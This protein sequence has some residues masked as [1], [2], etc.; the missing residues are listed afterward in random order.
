MTRNEIINELK[1]YFQIKNLVCKHANQKYSLM[2]WQFLSTEILE[3][4]LVLR[5]DILK[6]PLI[7]NDYPNGCFTQRGLRC[8][9]CEIVKGKSASK[10]MYLSAHVRGNAFDLQSPNMTAAQMRELI[11]VNASK[12]PHPIRIEK[13]V[14]WLHVDCDVPYE[15]AAKIVEF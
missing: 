7:C 12:L 10:T 2:A 13:D 9:L 6:V 11:K 15:S 14:T 3:T 5:K 8:N 4:L 1:P